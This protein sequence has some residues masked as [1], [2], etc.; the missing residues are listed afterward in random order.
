MRRTDLPAGL[1]KLLAKLTSKKREQ[2]FQTPGEL[3]DALLEFVPSR[4]LP[5]FVTP[6]PIP[7]SEL[8]DE[9]G[10][11][12]RPI[13]EQS[14]DSRFRLPSGD[15]LPLA[16]QPAKSPALLYTAIALMVFGVLLVGTLMV[17]IMSR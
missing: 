14:T 3:A 9:P 5:V 16:P 12:R 8:D 1:D 13:F 15:A 6:I 2:R 10:F 4:P 11:A 17:M 7:E